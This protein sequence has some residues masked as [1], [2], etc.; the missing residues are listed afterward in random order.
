MAIGKVPLTW[1]VRLTPDSV[2]PSVKEP[3]EVTVPVRVMPF[4]V[5]VPD[6]EV[7]VPPVPVA[8]MV[9]P[10]EL[11]VMVTPLPCVKFATV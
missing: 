8:A 10:P 4:T 3:E 5:P 2:P 6:T 1:V 7:T 11:L 9:M